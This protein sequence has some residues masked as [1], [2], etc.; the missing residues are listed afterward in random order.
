[1]Q[2]SPG[3]VPTRHLRM[4]SPHYSWFQTICRHIYS[5]ISCNQ[6]VWDDRGLH[7]QAKRCSQWQKGKNGLLWNLSLSIT[8]Q[9]ERVHLLR[10]TNHSF[11]W[12]RTIF[13]QL[14]HWSNVWPPIQLI[15]G[16]KNPF[17]L[18]TGPFKGQKSFYSEFLYSYLTMLNMKY[19]IF[20]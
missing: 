16:F 18:T 12:M 3:N 8:I 19:D 2:E 6:R 15:P 9:W 14:E 17:H 4:R 11:K 10:W 7:C 1:M 13:F 20:S 5:R